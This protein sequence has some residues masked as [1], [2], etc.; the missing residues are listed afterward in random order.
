MPQWARLRVVESSGQ[1]H[2]SAAQVQGQVLD[3]QICRS[4]VG[5]GGVLPPRQPARADVDS[6]VAVL[7]GWLFCPHLNHLDNDFGG[8]D[9]LIQACPFQGRVGIVLSSGEVGRG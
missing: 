9:H 1:R 8:L 7:S 4:H 3:C 5:T 2:C 6:S